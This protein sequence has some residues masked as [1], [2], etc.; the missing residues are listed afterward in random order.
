MKL[1]RIAHVIVMAIFSGVTAPVAAPGQTPEPGEAP[2]VDGALF[3]RPP[4]PAV[5]GRDAAQLAAPDLPAMRVELPP[6]AIPASRLD[7]I[8]RR[9]SDLNSD[10][11][12]DHADRTLLRQGFGPCPG[13]ERCRSDLNGDGRV[14]DGDETLLM[15]HLGRIC[16]V[17]EPQFEEVGYIQPAPANL[18]PPLPQQA[19]ADGS[20]AVRVELRSANAIGLRVQFKD[21]Q[22]SGGPQVRVYDPAG[23]AVLG[24]HTAPRLAQDGTWWAP[25]LFG[26]TIGIELT[27]P[28]G[29]A[30]PAPMPTINSVMYM[31]CTDP[32]ACH[33]GFPPGT[34]MG[35]HND[36]TCT[37]A[38]ADNE[39]QAVALIYFLTAGSCGRCTGALLTR[40]P[41][42]FS[43]LFMTANHCVSTQAQADTLEVFWLYN[44][45]SCG[46][47]P[48]N[49]NDIDRTDGALV[50]KRH[51]ATDWSLLGL[52]E[53]PPVGFYLGWD[54]NAWASGGAA[55]GIHHPRGTF[56]RISTGNSSG[57]SDASNFCDPS[58]TVMCSG[59]A[60]G[61]TTCIAVDTWN[62]AY[63]SGTTEPGSS[64]SPIFDGSSR[65]RGTLTGGPSGCA[66]VTAQYG[67]LD[68]A[69]TNLRY[70]LDN[71]QVPAT[72]V[73]VNGAVAGDAGNN[74][75]NERGT[76]ANPFNSVYEATFCVR[77][78]QEVRVTPG[79]YNERMTVRRPMRI[80]RSGAS[81]TVRIGG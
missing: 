20:R 8:R 27:V 63:T 53:T 14:D 67:R 31:Y 17:G 42:D 58:G 6:T 74:G 43:P 75:A 36:V 34:A 66:P 73:F 35:C 78:G 22:P 68:R 30:A 13:G 15:E 72:T 61:V 29:V 51:T 47:L 40:G 56:K 70:Y 2:F 49:L 71:A 46:G 38:W 1:E 50:L 33:D 37:P 45:P 32:V 55:T 18:L 79:T 19:R 25:T 52:F 44:T 4:R 7:E 69:F 77:S 26:D 24:P 81:G 3:V 80:T 23:T 28:A 21:V 57:S 62:V 16:N 10:G 41:G 5:A 59:C 60:G 11:I 9:A 48:P 12:V 76:A 54:A 64:G 39:A 65:M